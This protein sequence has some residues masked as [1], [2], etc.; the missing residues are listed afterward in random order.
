MDADHVE[1]PEPE[2]LPSGLSIIPLSDPDPPRVAVAAPRVWFGEI[3]AWGRTL[4]S[5]AVYAVLITTFVMQIARVEGTSMEPTLADQDRLVVNKLVYYLSDPRPGDIVML[6]Y[7][8]EPEKSFVKRVIA[9]PG[10]VVRIDD[11]R[12]F[13]NEVPMPETFVLPEFRGDQDY[14]PLQVPRGFYFVMGDHRTVSSDSR[15]W[16]PVPKKYI[17]GKVQLRWW[18]IPHA[19]VF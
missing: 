15:S 17:M 2:S 12:L 18:P 7:P 11:G 6:L 10:D 8:E 5:A 4:S 19:G 1:Q 16:G 3:V 13:V 9:E 14:G